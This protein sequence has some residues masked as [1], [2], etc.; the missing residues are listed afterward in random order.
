MLLLVWPF[1]DICFRPKLS[2]PP[3]FRIQG[4]SLSV[5][6]GGGEEGGG[7]A[8]ILVSNIVYCPDL[9]CPI[10]SCKYYQKIRPATRAYFQLLRR[11]SAEAF[12]ALQAKKELI[13]RF[14]AIFGNFWC[15]VVTLVIFSSNLCNFERNPKKPKKIQRKS[16]KFHKISKNP[17]NPKKNPKIQKIQTISKKSKESQKK[18]A[19]SITNQKFQKFQK[20]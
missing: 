17:K 1:E 7:R 8:E 13:M 2:S 6:K 15:L 14:W 11:A 18:I 10:V 12:F 19:K 20:W 16:K 3:Y 5:T 9:S 4:G